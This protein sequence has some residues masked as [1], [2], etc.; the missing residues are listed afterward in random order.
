MAAN[1]LITVTGTWTRA[2]DTPEEGIVHLRPYLVAVDTSPDPRIV[3]R[4][5]VSAVLDDTGAITT[6]VVASDDDGWQTTGPVPYVVTEHLAGAR[7]SWVAYLLGPGP[8]D[9]STVTPV[10]EAP[11]SVAP[12]PTPGPPGADSTVPGPPGPPG[13]PGAPGADS[14]VP[15][16]P[17]ADSTVPGPPG[18]PGAD[19]TV[20]GPEGPPGPPGT[21]YL[22]AAWNFNQNTAVPPASGTMR[23]NATTYAATTVLWIAETDRDGLDRSAGLSVAK[24]G[25]Q[26]I[27]QSAQG[28][29]LWDITAVADAGTYRTF[30]V[31]LVESSG[32]RPSASSPTTLY[33]AT[34]GDAG[35][36]TRA[37][38]TITTASLAAGASESGTV[39]LAK[40]YRLW[41]IITTAAAR[42]RLYTTTAK[43]DADAS[44]PVGTDPTGNHG[45][46][47]E[48]VTTLAGLLDLDLS[49]TVDGF[50]GKGTPDGVIPYRITNTDVGTLAVTVTL[51]WI[52]TE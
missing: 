21:A 36:Q 8:V 49:P 9:L 23:M 31:T 38:A 12:T 3:T 6:A 5:S 51:F 52:R 19:S 28:R 50:D 41:R 4:A 44:R 48:V 14:M 43:R 11:L 29:A 40:G 24:A 34:V 45:C 1:E 18:P 7:R 25:D 22:N 47:L 35:L 17:G 20:P 30:G 10:D 2:D 32:T 13:P 46:V 33:F 27:M 16:P 15:G 37:T 42:V 26:I 39:T